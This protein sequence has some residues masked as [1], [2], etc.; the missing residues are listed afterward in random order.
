MCHSKCSLLLIL[1][2]DGEIKLIKTNRKNALNNMLL[3][4]EQNQDKMA[5]YP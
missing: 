5:K 4:E 3:H 2:T 1:N